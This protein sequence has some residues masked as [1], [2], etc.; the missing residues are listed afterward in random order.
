[1]LHDDGPN[2]LYNICCQCGRRY[3]R[4][5]SAFGMWTGRCDICG[6]V[7]GVANALHDFDLTDEGVRLIKEAS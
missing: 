6:T 1:M 5:K 4:P 7:T 3:G 2:G